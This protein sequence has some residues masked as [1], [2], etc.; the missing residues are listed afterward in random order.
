MHGLQKTARG[1][2][3][4]SLN[5][6]WISQ[7]CENLLRLESFLTFLQGLFSWG[8]KTV[9]PEPS[10]RVELVWKRKVNTCMV[11]VGFLNLFLLIPQLFSSNMEKVLLSW[12]GIYY[13]VEKPEIFFI[14]YI[15]F[16]FW[17]TLKNI[18]CKKI[19][20]N[21]TKAVLSTKRTIYKKKFTSKTCLWIAWLCLHIFASDMANKHEKHEEGLLKHCCRARLA[22]FTLSLSLIAHQIQNN[23]MV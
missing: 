21:S 15:S 6:L 22:C 7:F 23:E 2:V 17:L 19:I 3:G 20:S 11:V 5:I 10:F 12:L 13:V 4:I 16:Y 8:Q 9:G 14:V 1:Q 18:Y